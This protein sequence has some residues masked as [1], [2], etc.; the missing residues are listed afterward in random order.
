MSRFNQELFH[1]SVVTLEQPGLLFA[2]STSFLSVK[3][4]KSFA[5]MA[6][7][8][9]ATHQSTRPYGRASAHSQH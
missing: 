9:A 8:E 6:S 2:S 5:K 3:K 1:L 4:Q 7:G